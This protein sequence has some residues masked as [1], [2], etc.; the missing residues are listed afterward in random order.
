MTLTRRIIALGALLF[1]V[2]LGGAGVAPPPRPV[3]SDE[4]IEDLNKIS[5]WLNGLTTLS[6]DFVQVSPSGNIAQGT[7]YLAKPDRLR[8]DYRPPSPTLIVA[9]AGRIYVKNNRL[10]TVDRTSVADTPLGLLLGDKIDLRRNPAVLSVDHL[11]GALVVHAR[12]STNRR[13]DN[14]IISFATSPSLELRQWTV[15][16][17]SGGAT[18]VA[19]SNVR[20][21]VDLPQTLFAVPVKT[22]EIRQGAN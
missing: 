5:A 4:N 19:L 14:I 10:G 12:S 13:Q 9:T 6:A 18:S 15:K 16:D 7:F 1:P 20:L 17:A 8:F 11:P 22:P 3:F 21:G 2:L